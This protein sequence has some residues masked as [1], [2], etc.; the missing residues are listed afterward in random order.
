MQIY[1]QRIA[2]VGFDLDGTLIRTEELNLRAATRTCERFD[3]PYVPRSPREL[4]GMTNTALFRL[5]T[6]RFGMGRAESIGVLCA[7]KREYYISHLAEAEPVP[8]AVAFV[9]AVW[10]LGVPTAVATAASNES[11]D[12]A[13][14]ALGLER[15]KFSVLLPADALPHRSAKPDPYHWQEAA[16]LCGVPPREFLVVEDSPRGIMSSAGAGCFTCGITTTHSAAELWTA[17]AEIVVPSFRE[18][19]DVLGVDL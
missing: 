11:L 4:F 10:K 16:R 15:E 14:R 18:L 2:G 1:G 8:D 19:A 13:L 5:I 7:Y 12:A 17:A 9:R 6:E 3:I